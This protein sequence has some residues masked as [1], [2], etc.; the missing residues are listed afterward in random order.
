[1][2]PPWRARFSGV[3]ATRCGSAVLE[4]FRDPGEQILT[5][6][7]GCGLAGLKLSAAEGFLLSRVDGA[8]PWRILREIGGIPADEVDCCLQGWLDQGLLSVVDAGAAAARGAAATLDPDAGTQESE[9][10]RVIDESALDGGLEID[11]AVQRRILW[12]ESTLD[13]PYH[14]ILGVPVGTEPKALKRAYFRLSKEFHPDRYF[15]KQVGAYLGRLEKIFKKLL[16]AHEMLSD[17]ALCGV[18]NTET[19]A[20]GPA[21]LESKQGPPVS[22]VTIEKA[23]RAPRPLTKLERLKQRMPFR[24]S[25]TVIEARRARAVPIFD[26]GCVSMKEGRFQEAEASFRIAISFDPSCAEFKAALGDL[27]VLAAG[28]SAGKLLDR[29]SGRMSPEELGKA[30]SLLEDVLL[31]RPHDPD[32]N[33]RAARISME[34]GRFG[35]AEEYA[36][37]MLA[38]VPESAEA[39]TILGRIHAERKQNE[40]AAKLFEMALKYDEENP[41]ARR[42]LAAIRFGAHEHVQ[43]G[44]G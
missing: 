37:T 24:V 8:T 22:E 26:A 7:E 2:R 25:G 12:F 21:S 29:T 31:Y 39:Y 16:E 6:V 40:Q 23:R 27:R 41:E 42:A 34:L 35:S 33:E 3:L 11:L 32:L 44:E 43:G 20:A 38:R 19:A 14:E 30:L 17:P 9:S 1:M 15:R 13:R 28:E 10:V 36:E 18:D 5:L 4:Q